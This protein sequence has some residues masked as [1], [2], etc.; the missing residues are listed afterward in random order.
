M[1]ST[2]KCPICKEPYKF[3][4]FSAADQSACPDCI[5]KAERK[6]RKKDFDLLGEFRFR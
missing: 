1:E 4:P 5:S 2:I 6:N 3:Y